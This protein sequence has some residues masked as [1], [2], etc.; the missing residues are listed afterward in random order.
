MLTQ[1]PSK[2]SSPPAA[3]GQ[4]AAL[5]DAARSGESDALT[6]LVVRFDGLVR[7]VALSV[8]HK[9]EDAD[10]VA[11]QTWLA[12][13]CNIRS[14]QCG[15]ALPGWLATTAR[16]E[17]LRL[18]RDRSRCVPLDEAWLHQMEDHTDGPEV[19]A[20]KQELLT[21]LRLALQRLP[22]RQ[23][24]LLIKLVGYRRPYAEVA[25]DL[26]YAKGSLGPLRGRYLRQLYEA[27]EHWHVS[28]A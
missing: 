14:I 21:C 3:K 23:Q 19:R 7:G 15:E 20:E 26:Q 6:A 24:Q 11:Q 25:A 13:Y 9:P 10:D 8:T 22:Q 1:T 4:I 12:L 27:L 16:R 18:V 17:G 5:V 2:P 28:A